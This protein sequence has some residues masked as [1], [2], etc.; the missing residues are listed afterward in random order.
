MSKDKENYEPLPIVNRDFYL[1]WP[2]IIG[3]VSEK[4]N[5][6]ENS[7]N[8]KIK[9]KGLSRW[10]LLEKKLTFPFTIKIFI[11]ENFS[12]KFKYSLT[13][14]SFMGVRIINVQFLWLWFRIEVIK[15]KKDNPSYIFMG[16]HKWK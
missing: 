14:N 13:K 5:L 8:Y 11:G 9:F 4:N 16:K 15:T 6:F 3:N 10:R 2:G 12:F 1:K 7:Y